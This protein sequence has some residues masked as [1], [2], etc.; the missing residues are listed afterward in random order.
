MKNLLGG[1]GNEQYIQL[2]FEKD[3]VGG[4]NLILY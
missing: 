3:E 2:N 4:Y 1:G